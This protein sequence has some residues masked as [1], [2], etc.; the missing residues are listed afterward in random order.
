MLNEIITS[1]FNKLF[2]SDCLLPFP[3]HNYVL[4]KYHRVKPTC[5]LASR[6]NYTICFPLP[7]LVIVFHD[8]YGR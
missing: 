3:L 8:E 2:L 4:T 5:F 1:Y 6:G 7:P